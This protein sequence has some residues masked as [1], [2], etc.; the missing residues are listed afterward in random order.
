MSESTSPTTTSC[1]RWDDLSPRV[2]YALLRLRVDVFVVEQACAYPELDGRDLEPGAEHR[3]AHPVGDPAT[4]LAYLRV[5]DDGPVHGPSDA[6]PS[7]PRRT[8]P[9]RRVGRVVAAPAA[10]GRRLAE[11][12]VAEVVAAHGR[13]GDVVL[14]AQSHLADWYA[15]HGFERTGP[16]FVEDGIPHTPMRR[17][18]G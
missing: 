13:D 2:A 17:P 7:G 5:L 18:R 3:W 1:A 11:Q 14:D 8:V 9:L 16:D 4:V 10:R 15:R 6:A 12:L